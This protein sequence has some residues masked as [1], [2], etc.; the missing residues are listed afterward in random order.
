[1]T[2]IFFLEAHPDYESSPW[3]FMLITSQAV[4]E[5][6]WPADIN[7][8]SARRVNVYLHYKWISPKLTP[9][10][11]IN[12]ESEDSALSFSF[13]DSLTI[14]DIRDLAIWDKLTAT[15]VLMSHIWM[16][17]TPLRDHIICAPPK[18]HVG[19]QKREHYSPLMLWIYLNYGSQRGYDKRFQ[20]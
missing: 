10:C 3:F 7:I 15:D 11:D 12:N 9:V 2:T 13:F 6:F 1:M 4:W 14:V 19:E 8:F 5:A 18:N 16:Y 20:H 17:C